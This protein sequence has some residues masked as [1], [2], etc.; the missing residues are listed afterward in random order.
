MSLANRLT[1]AE[2]ALAPTAQE[3]AADLQTARTKRYWAAL[4]HLLNFGM[5]RAYAE[6][7]HAEL[8][9]GTPHTAWSALTRR[10][11]S[12]ASCAS[13]APEAVNPRRGPLVIALAHC[14]LLTTYP[15]DVDFHGQ[16]RCQG[17][18]LEAPCR[19]WGRYAPAGKVIGP[20]YGSVSEPWHWQDGLVCAHCGGALRWPP[21]SVNV[22]WRDAAG[23]AWRWHPQDGTITPREEQ[24]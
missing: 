19:R 20:G 17:C 23:T 24:P 1:K 22:W 2:Q 7:V 13:W 4:E 15:D 8:V 14:E 6:L 21:S 16:L 9:A 18:Q 5:L 10:A 3:Q 11:T 12:L